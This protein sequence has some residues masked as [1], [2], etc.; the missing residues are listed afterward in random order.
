LTKKAKKN[1]EE[2]ALVNVDDDDESYRSE[3]VSE[4]KRKSSKSSRKSSATKE[5]SKKRKADELDTQDD[6]GDFFVSD[7]P[8]FLAHCIDLDSHK[9]ALMEQIK[10]KNAN[11]NDFILNN[12]ARSLGSDQAHYRR[13]NAGP[14]LKSFGIP[15]T[16]ALIGFN[17]VRGQYF[18]QFHGV[19]VKKSDMEDVRA[20][21]GNCRNFLT[22][23]EETG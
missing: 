15:Y 2:V 6:A 7:K 14:T 8:L 10:A 23:T 13:L 19:I 12:D 22:T 16:S 9:I 5:N 21:F 18:P 3:E 20:I 11:R 4:P 1:E 17:K